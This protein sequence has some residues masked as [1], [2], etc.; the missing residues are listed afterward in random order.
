[1]HILLKHNENTEMNTIL[2]NLI[3]KSVML[4]HCCKYFKMPTFKTF[5][6]NEES[7]Q[8]KIILPTMSVCLQQRGKNVTYTSRAVVRVA[9]YTSKSEDRPTAS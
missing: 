1:M 7:A 3:M 6:C 2:K 5:A 4:S 9:T 8:T